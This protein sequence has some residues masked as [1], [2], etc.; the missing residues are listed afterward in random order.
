MTNAVLGI[1][2]RVGDFWWSVWDR[3][4]IFIMVMN[5]HA[6]SDKPTPFQSARST[7]LNTM[8]VECE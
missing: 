6:R 1:I 8:V 3:R 7:A 5:Q 4:E 2:E